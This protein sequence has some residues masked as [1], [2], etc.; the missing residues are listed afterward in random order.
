MILPGLRFEFGWEMWGILAAFVLFFAF[1][2]IAPMIYA[3]FKRKKVLAPDE[4]NGSLETIRK[5]D[6]MPGE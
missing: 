1:L 2:L 3:Y 6:Y 5:R 4:V